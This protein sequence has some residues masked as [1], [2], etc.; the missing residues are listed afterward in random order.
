MAGVSAENM[1]TSFIGVALGVASSVTTAVHA[2]VVKR[3][4]AV[5]SG[6][7]DLAY[8]SNLLSALVI[9]PFVLLSGEVFTVMDMVAGEG[10]E[11][12]FGTFLIGACVTVSS[13]GCL[14]V[15]ASLICHLAAG[16][17]RL[18]HLHRRVPFHQGH[19]AH[20]SHGLCW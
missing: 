17:L 15:G 18:P 14:R 7:L 10:A 20:L 11:G 5:V 12:Q 3:S 4:L 6:T 9:L 13:T 1:S 2:I 8:Y 19:F 16:C